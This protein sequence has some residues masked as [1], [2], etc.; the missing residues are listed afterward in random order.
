MPHLLDTYSFTE[1]GAVYAEAGKGVEHLKWRLDGGELGELRSALSSSDRKGQ[2]LSVHDCL[3]AYIVA[4]LNCNR[5]VAIRRVAN[6]SS[7][8]NV[9]APFIDKNVAGNLI[10]NVPSG[11]IPLDMAG[12]AATIR[13]SHVRSREPDYLNDW[14]STA[15]NL[16]LGTANA[17]KSFFFAPHDDV[18]TINSNTSIDWCGAHFGFPDGSRFHTSGVAKYYF[19]PF[20]SNPVKGDD[21]VWRLR[22]GSVDVSMGVPAELKPKLLETFANGVHYMLD[23]PV[24]QL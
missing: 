13:A 11:A 12:I 2:L 9:E 3:T 7:Y 1:L 21:G 6:A 16:M 8:R 15:S 10:Q 20:R 17:G 19:R 4:V 23:Y 22:Q 24:T 18:M 5:D 14:I